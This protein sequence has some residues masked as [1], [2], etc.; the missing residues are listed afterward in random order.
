MRLEVSQTLSTPRAW[1]VTLLGQILRFEATKELALRWAIAFVTERWRRDRLAGA[2]FVQD[3]KR[4][5]LV[6][7]LTTVE[8]APSAE[9]EHGFLAGE[10]SRLA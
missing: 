1:K 6:R 2:V 3:E 5:V 7:H 10:N 4:G 8:M 9:D